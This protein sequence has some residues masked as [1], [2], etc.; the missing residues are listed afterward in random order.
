MSGFFVGWARQRRRWR[1]QRLR[2]RITRIGFWYLGFTLAVGF[3][4]TNTGNNLLFLL[5]GLLLAGILLSGVISQL[6]LRGLSVERLLPSDATVGKPVLVGLRITNRKRRLASYAIVAR[7]MTSQGPTGQVFWVLIEPG[8][9]K[10]LSYRWEPTRRGRRQFERIDVVTRFPFGLFEKWL[11]WESPAEVVVFPREVPAPPL[12]FSAISPLG[13]RPSAS[14]GHGTE[15]FGLRDQ[16]AGD[17]ARSIHWLTS[18]R[19]GRPVVVDRERERRRRVSVLLDNRIEALTEVGR[20]AAPGE[21]LDRMVE[22]TAAVV[23]RADQEGSEVGLA[24]SDGMVPPGVSPQHLRRILAMLALIEPVNGGPA[25]TP[26]PASDR[27]DVRYTPEAVTS[28]PVPVPLPPRAAPA[29]T[30]SVA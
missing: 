6:T 23:R 18:A 28:M 17:D 12:A 27:I 26:A 11:Q 20:G 2:L 8:Q 22:A 1:R 9:S 15:F 7:D 3:A 30:G 21:V 25:P 24:T 14:V 16:R 10:D 5:F 29:A 19:R 4:G 13:E